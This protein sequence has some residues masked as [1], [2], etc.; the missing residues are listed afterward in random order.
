MEYISSKR[1]SG[2]FLCDLV[3]DTRDEEN[4]VLAR[5]R[6]CFVVLNLYPYNNG[7]LM[8][9]PNRHLSEIADLTKSERLEMFQHCEKAIEALRKAQ[10]A[11]GFNI[12]FNL[13]KAAGAGLEDHLHLHIVPRWVGD[14]NFMPALGEVKLIS[15][16]LRDTYNTLKPFFGGR[17]GVVSDK[18]P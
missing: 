17:A 1:K 3:R 6:Y 15:Q 5:G 14:T 11:Q 7:H 10:K 13:G 2:C 4:L 18:S 8:V 9:S 16:H 12:G